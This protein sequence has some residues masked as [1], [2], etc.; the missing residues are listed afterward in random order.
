MINKI[1]LPDGYH[2]AWSDDF[3]SNNINDSVWGAETH[4]SGWSDGERQEY[5]G[6]KCIGFKDSCLCIRPKIETERTGATRYVSARISTFGRQ[7][8]KY[9]RIVARIKVPKTRGL[10][11]YV[12]LMPDEGYDEETGEYKDFPL[13]GQIDMVE[14]EGA[15]ADEAVSRVAFGYPYT[16]RVGNYRRLNTDFSSDFHIFSCE[17]DQDEIIFSCDGK[18]YYRTSFWF[19]RSGET[20]EPYPAPFN[21]PFHLVIGVA[22]GG[23]KVGAGTEIP[24]SFDE[25]SELLVDYVRVYQKER[26]DRQV[27]RPARILTLNTD[28]TDNA[29]SVKNS[30]SNAFYVAEGDLNANVVFMEDELI[31]TPSFISG[32][33]GGTR[34]LQG[35]FPFKKGETYEFSFDGRVDEPRTIRCQFESDKDGKLIIDPYTVNLESHWQRHRML[36]EVNEDHDKASVVFVIDAI[37]KASIHIRNI[38][39]KKRPVNTNRRKLI[40][41]CGVWAD[42][43]NYSLFLRSLQTEE[44]KNNYVITSFTFNE[45]NTGTLQAELEVEFADLLGRMELAA[46]IIFSEM[47]KSSEVLERLVQIGHEK[48]IPVITFQHPL[49]GCINADFEYENGFRQI[50]EHVVNVHGAKHLDMMAGIRDN[51][52]S[53]ARIRVFK[54]VLKE[55]GIDPSSAKIFYGDFW[56]ARAGEVLDDALDNGYEIPEAIICANDSMAIGVCDSLSKRGIK[57]PEDVMVTGF[58]GIWQALFHAPVVTTCEL[59]YKKIPEQILLRIKNWEEHK[60][61]G[62]DTF[63]IPYKPLFMQS[64]G[65][66]MDSQFPWA[67]AV[68]VLTEESQNSFRHMLEMGHF[69]S[70]MTSSDNLDDAAANLRNSVWMWKSQYYFVGITQEEEC[71]HSIFHGRGNKYSH[72]H[73]FYRMKYPIP[74]YDL[75]LAPDSNINVLLFRQIRSQKEIFGYVANG[76]DR[77]SLRSEQRF[78]EFSLFVNAAVNAVNNNR[79]LITKNKAS[80]LLSEQ[81]YLTGLY[82][83]RGFFASITK[84]LNS[85]A[86]SGRILSLFSVDMDKLKT[87]NDAYGHENGD[88]AIQTLARALQKFV[89][90]DGIAAR[91]GGDE[92]ALAIINDKRYEDSITDVRNEIERSADADPAMSDRDFE[93]GISLGVSERVIGR[94]IDIEDMILEADS[95]M[96]ADK[97][98]RK[99]LR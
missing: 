55:R 26:Y 3:N 7:D 38:T 30:D 76:Y 6:D 4:A 11:S 73:K 22:V 91:Y 36:F 81:D 34:L 74:D 96:Y 59:D 27:V 9:G 12:R 86:N 44:I 42:S 75:I 23:N 40:A 99:R 60:K 28:G 97:M 24:T 43:D 50:V 46:I 80:E 83:R 67:N 33:S 35:G 69:V 15:R 63:T 14:I 82:N 45:C 66:K 70:R 13:H 20:E 53:D 58:D 5:S 41:V 98:A 47:I 17:W 90:D 49:E 95:K 71:C 31:I 51:R 1:S 94:N 21:K 78:E 54:E 32:T 2:V 92:F 57:V 8:F 64:C 79:K 61:I 84:M 18:E 56:Q 93:V 89:K 37:S 29:D 77:V 10:L 87:I 88:V 39:L 19:K 65:C 25:N 72:A 52:F 48:D 16:Q 85:P 62:Q 68:E